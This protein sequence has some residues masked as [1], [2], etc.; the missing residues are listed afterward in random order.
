MNRSHLLA[1]TNTFSP[2]HLFA[3]LREHRDREGLSNEDVAASLGMSIHT[4]QAYFSGRPLKHIDPDLVRAI[5]S[6][7][8][9]AP[10]QAFLLAGEL[11]AD[12]LIESGSVDARLELVATMLRA[13]PLYSG[14]APGDEWETL[15]RQTRILI[16]L[17]YEQATCQH[18][19]SA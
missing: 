1:T 15:P 12:D 6:F 7:I 9:L 18:I 14:F 16:A 2:G 11:K 3:K 13:D 4:L 10:L 19:L 8:G 17:L 5:A